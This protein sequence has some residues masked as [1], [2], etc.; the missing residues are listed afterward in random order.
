MS[1]VKPVD[2]QQLISETPFLAPATRP[3]GP[4]KVPVAVD[5]QAKTTSDDHKSKKKSHKSAKDSGSSD[6]Q[7]DKKHVSKAHRKRDRSRSPV[8]KKSAVSKQ[9]Q[10]ATA[11]ADPSSG[12]ES[13]DQCGSTKVDMEHPSTGQDKVHAGPS[14]QSS[15]GSHQPVTG[16]FSTGACA[17]PTGYTRLSV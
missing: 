5:A 13:A 8:P 4:V 1:A 14:G 2:S 10:P 12:P 17:F 16:Q 6:K 9:V 7:S 11:P 3:T 15:S